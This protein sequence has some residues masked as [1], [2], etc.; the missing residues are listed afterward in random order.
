MGPALPCLTCCLT[1]HGRG[2]GPD[3]KPPAASDIAE[4]SLFPSRA[5]EGVARMA[6][7]PGER[8]PAVLAASWAGSVALAGLKE[9]R[10][11]QHE[12]RAGGTSPGPYTHRS[13]GQPGTSCGAE[14][15]GAPVPQMLRELLAP[16]LRFNPTARVLPGAAQPEVRPVCQQ[17]CCLASP[18][19]RT[20]SSCL[21]RAVPSPWRQHCRPSSALAAEPLPDLCVP[22]SHPQELLHYLIGTL[23]LLIACIVVASRRDSHSSL[24]AGTVRLYP[25]GTSGVL[26]CWLLLIL[27]G[28]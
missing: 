28:G 12:N 15:R 24:V 1:R 5:V 18:L 19:P 16:L 3:P 4:L 27:L 9:D 7:D 21:L 13:A 23:L 14:G 2:Q 22:S 8:K 26:T 11:P 20:A 17:L 10:K 6:V 25:W